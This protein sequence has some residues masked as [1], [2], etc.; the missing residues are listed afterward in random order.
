L[1]I[2]I[3]L[4]YLF[5]KCELGQNWK[6][7]SGQWFS[8][9]NIKYD[10]IIANFSLMHFFTDLF[11]EQL[12]Q[13]VSV[14]SKFIFN[15]VTKPSNTNEWTESE[16]FLRIENEHVIYKF[17]WVHNDV[18]TEPYISEEKLMTQLD[19]SRWIVLNKFTID[20]KQHKL[21]NFY[22]W[23]VIEKK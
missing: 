5:N 13:I 15:L 1:F 8:Y 2:S 19:K 6:E 23:W 4:L 14:G 9:Y 7:T 3:C 10:Y 22:T 21:S 16:S 18:K 20:S 12:N 17:E 11:W